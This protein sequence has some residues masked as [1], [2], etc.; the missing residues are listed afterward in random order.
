MHFDQWHAS[1]CRR[2]TWPSP[3]SAF[4]FI[5]TPL[6]ALIGQLKHL[7]NEI[8]AAEVCD[9]LEVFVCVCWLLV[10]CARALLYCMC[11]WKRERDSVSW[12]KMKED[13]ILS[14]SQDQITQSKCIL[15]QAPMRGHYH[16]STF[17]RFHIHSSP[18]S[19]V[20]IFFN[21]YFQF[22]LLFFS[23]PPF[24]LSSSLCLSFLFLSLLLFSSLPIH[25]LS[26]MTF[27]R[28][29]LGGEEQEWETTF[30]IGFFFVC[31]F[32]CSGQ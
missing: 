26:A 5:C 25:Y 24:S 7:L 22:I 13:I 28:L 19:S 27:K 15:P 14:L 6:Q 11:V 12:D 2:S 9:P 4:G 23:L 31:V 17:Y 18:H 1:A 30:H 20:L 10:S 29:S 8:F 16:I 21:D 3:L 32:F